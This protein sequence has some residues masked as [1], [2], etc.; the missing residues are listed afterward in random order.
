MKSPR[1]LR[2]SVGMEVDEREWNP[3]WKARHPKNLFVGMG[4]EGDAAVLH[5]TQAAVRE[6]RMAN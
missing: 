5:R 6:L 4:A 3:V 1:R 2:I